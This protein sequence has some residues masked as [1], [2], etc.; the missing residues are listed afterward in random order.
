M[1]LTDEE[2]EP[3]YLLLPQ[4]H[5]PLFFVGRRRRRSL[6]LLGENSFP[7]FSVCTSHNPPARRVMFSITLVCCSNI[8]GRRPCSQVITLEPVWLGTT[9][10]PHPPDY[11]L[12]HCMTHPH[13]CCCMTQH[14][15]LMPSLCMHAGVPSG[16]VPSA[17]CMVLLYQWILHHVG[18]TW[19]CLLPS[20]TR[21]YHDGRAATPY[22]HATLTVCSSPW[23]WP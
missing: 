22:F 16:V 8:H 12:V 11:W 13:P 18:I 21:R 7:P 3:A 15:S 1:Y 14:T 5:A 9:G 23:S 17:S 2:R 4:R 19:V 20:C 10:L 6:G